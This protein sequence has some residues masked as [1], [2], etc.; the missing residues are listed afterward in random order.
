M[1]I[2]WALAALATIGLLA[3]CSS[4]V[5]GTGSTALTGGASG[6]ARSPDFPNRSGSA[7]QPSDTGEAPAPE[8]SGSS[9]S[10]GSAAEAATPCP[11]VSY[12]YAHLAFACITTGM[13]QQLDGD[14]WP[15]SE[16]KPVDAAGSGWVLDEGA[17]HWG[18]T[19]G[20][21]LSAIAENVRQQMVDNDNYGDNPTVHTDASKDTTVDGAPAHL[22]QTTFTIDPAWAKANKV[23]VKQEKLWIIAIEVGSDDVSLWYVS[24]PDLVSTL[25]AKV[26]TTIASIKII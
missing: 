7:P 9:G 23:T 13:T 18:A 5:N 25:W 26:P 24:V 2:R 10:S 14:V 17:G 4:V 19:E 6:A 8:P 12:P 22:L 15:L 3:G 21:S 11:N 16:I 20:H 1:K